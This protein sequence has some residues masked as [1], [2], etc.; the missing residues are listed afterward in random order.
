MIIENVRREVA[1]GSVS[2]KAHV[3]FDSAVRSQ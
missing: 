2:L 1:E 3:R